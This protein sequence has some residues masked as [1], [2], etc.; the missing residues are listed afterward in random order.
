M[1]S[2]SK[3]NKAASAGLLARMSKIIGGPQREVRS[4]SA[5][6]PYPRLLTLDPAATGLVRQS[7][8]YACWHLGVRP[9]WLRV[10]GGADLGA[11]LGGL[12]THA[13]IAACDANGG[14]FVAWALLPSRDIA[15][16]AG[17]LA[18][19]L[20]PAFQHIAI[21]GEVMPSAGGLVFPLPPDTPV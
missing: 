5:V 15:A 2:P 19:Q 17:S 4:W 7:G 3:P 21:E 12:Q 13:V 1:T 16:A 10:G 9:R 8:V 11:L 18:E 20:R 6:P 14:V